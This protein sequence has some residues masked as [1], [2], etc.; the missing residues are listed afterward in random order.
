MTKIVGPFDVAT[1]KSDS[2]SSEVIVTQTQWSFML[3]FAT[4]FGWL[5]AQFHGFLNAEF[6]DN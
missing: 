4:K 2:V 3:S 1:L 6:H 5:M